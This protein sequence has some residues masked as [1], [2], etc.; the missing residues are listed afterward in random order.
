MTVIGCNLERVNTVSK[1][2]ANTAKGAS[3]ATATSATLTLRTDR[4]AST[5]PNSNSNSS[6]SSKGC[7]ASSSYISNFT[8][9]GPGS[10]KGT[11]IYGD[12]GRPLTAAG[13]LGLMDGWWSWANIVME[14]VCDRVL[15][16][17]CLAFF[18]LCRSMW[19]SFK[20][21]W[22]SEWSVV[23]LNHSHHEPL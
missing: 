13:V 14:C 9:R 8:S 23:G 7:R 3:T 21:L 18:L 12:G 19:S 1:G 5:G 17:L 15:G 10:K 2:M 6:S 16:S 20:R 11:M 22:H 4:G